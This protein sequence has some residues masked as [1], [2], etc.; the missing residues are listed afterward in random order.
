MGVRVIGRKLDRSSV[1]GF[2]FNRL[3]RDAQEHA[4]VAVRVGVPRFDRYRALIF[5]DCVVEPAVRLQN[6]GVIAVP[7]R[8][9]G[10]Q[11]EALLDAG[12]RFVCSPLLVGE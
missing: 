7:V 9:I 10:G 1:G 5:S 12:Y 11:L 8:L 6:N 3:T 4:E 2:G